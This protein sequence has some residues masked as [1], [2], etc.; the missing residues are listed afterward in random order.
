M[1]NSQPIQQFRSNKNS[2]NLVNDI[3]EE[4]EN[5]NDNTEQEIVNQK[6]KELIE[7]QN[8]LLLQK[9][10]QEEELLE[11]KKQHEEM[12]LQQQHEQEQVLQQQQEAMRQEQEAMLRQEENLNKQQ[13]QIQETVKNDEIN[14]DSLLQEDFIKTKDVPSE[15]FKV[16][17]N[18]NEDSTTSVLEKCLKSLKS[19]VIVGIII[20]VL[21]LPITD[22][23]FGNILPN[24][25]FIQ[26]NLTII[27]NVIKS[28]VGAVI[29]YLVDFFS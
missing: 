16:N 10:K 27:T 28:L 3:L 19:S 24:K 23:I 2:D 13:N 12:L 21:L 6:Q 8:Q 20:L 18:K 26:N 22:K 14:L 5:A 4:I 29:F 17:L 11:Q 25:E 7:Q 9:Q 1:P 15:S